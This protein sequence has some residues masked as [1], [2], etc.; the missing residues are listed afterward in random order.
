MVPL[1]R[2]LVSYRFSFFSSYYS[3]LLLERGITSSEAHASVPSGLGLSRGLGLG[4]LSVIHEN[5]PVQGN[6]GT[7]M[8]GRDAGQS[9]VAMLLEMF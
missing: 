7:F 6:P 9:R 5:L 3:Q 4:L 2:P 1:A 8:S